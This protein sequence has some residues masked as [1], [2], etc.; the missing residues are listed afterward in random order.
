VLA[1]S[2]FFIYFFGIFQIHIASS[3]RNDGLNIKERIC[4]VSQKITLT[5]TQYLSQCLLLCAIDH[6]MWC[7]TKEAL[8]ALSSFRR[9]RSFGTFV[10]F[11]LSL[12]LVEVFVF[13]ISVLSG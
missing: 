5:H 12:S 9:Q 6:P 8:D 1:T 4:Y 7:S 2:L 3:N 10:G 13:E 11:R